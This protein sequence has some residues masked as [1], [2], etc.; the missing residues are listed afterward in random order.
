[1]PAPIENVP[2][3]ASRGFRRVG[4]LET[5]T[6][7]VDGVND[8]LDVDI[9]V[10]DSG[11]QSDQPDLRVVGGVDCA[12]PTGNWNDV[13]GHGTIVAGIAAAIDNSIGVVGV[14]AGARLWSVRVLD[15][16]NGGEDAAILCGIDCASRSR[17]AWC[18]SLE[19]AMIP[20]TVPVRSRVPTAR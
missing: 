12:D 5:D 7:K 9:A 18:T 19:Q 6:V 14:V 15:E 13:E 11:I 8:R 3:I 20:P 1:V 16:H 4:G 17:P 10:L 2:Q